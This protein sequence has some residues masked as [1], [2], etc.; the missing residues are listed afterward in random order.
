MTTTANTVA[1]DFNL[2]KLDT[3]QL[4]KH[5][6]A[7]IHSQS[8]IA[9]FG[10]RGLGKTFISKQVIKEMGMLEAYMNLSVYERTDLAGYPSLMNSEHC[11]SGFVEYLLPRIFE[12]MLHGDKKVV[13]LLDECD[14]ADPSLWAP[15]LEFVQFHS[16]NGKHFPNL[17]C[18]IMTGNLISEGGVRPSL[19]LLDRTEKYLVEST[20]KAWLD[21]AKESAEIH[22]SVFQF[23]SDNPNR[24]IG[25]VDAQ[26]NYA[27]ESPRGWHN[28]SRMANVGEASG[29]DVDVII[30]KV[31]GYVGKKAGIDYRMYY[32]NYKV[33][34]PIVDRI[35]AGEDYKSEW[36]K[37]SPTEKLY[38][39]V[40]VCGRFST[41]LDANTP[42]TPPNKLIKTVGKF[43]QQ[44][45]YENVLASVRQVLSIK[46]VIRYNLDE[47]K[48]WEGLLPK[49]TETA[50]AA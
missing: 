2:E 49:I 18:V 45:G 27:D 16:I 46:R 33:L 29:W 38:T 12:P 25:P 48:D 24:L 34:L 32:T 47:H 10:R 23:I 20:A 22:P 15:L 26:D 7:S 50:D 17:Q 19:P 43:M 9:I 37:L 36:K 13:A 28:A 41:E 21:W 4:Q 40:I 6:Q 11:K 30:D 14:K 39:T 35:M 42:A 5:I 31:S 1:S 8:N 3:F 44:A